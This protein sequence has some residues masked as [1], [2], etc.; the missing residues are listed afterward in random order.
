MLGGR[1]ATQ[2]DY[3]RLE[4]WACENLMKFNKAKCKFLYPGSGQAPHEYRLDEEWIES[5]SE[6]KDLGL[7]V[8]KKLHLTLQCAL[9][10]QKAKSGLYQKQGGQQVKEGDSARLLHSCETPPGVLHSA[11]GHPM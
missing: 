9:T 4:R 8:D 2:R 11:L 10:A 3:Y 1:D 6:E 5:S 7:L